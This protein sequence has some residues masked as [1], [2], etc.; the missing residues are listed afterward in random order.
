MNIGEAIKSVRKSKGITQAQ[1]AGAAGIT[2]ATLSQIENG[3]RP[4]TKTMKKICAEL[5]TAE[6]ILWL[7]TADEAEV[8]PSKR[9]VYNL[10]FPVIKD[11][12]YKLC[13]E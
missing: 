8:H 13:S 10:L 12:V 1:L 9:E 6:P 2:Q 3:K 11:L 4:G 7:M 5:K